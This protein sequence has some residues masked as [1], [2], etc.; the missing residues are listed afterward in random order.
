[1]EN[2]FKFDNPDITEG[3]IESLLG[4]KFTIVDYHESDGILA[5]NSQKELFIFKIENIYE[6]SDFQKIRHEAPK[7]VKQE[8]ELKRITKAYIICIV[9]FDFGQGNDYVYHGTT[10]FNGMT[11]G[12]IF[13]EYYI[14]RINS[15]SGVPT[16]PLDEWIYFLK[17][18]KVTPDA[19]A[20]GL[21]KVAGEFRQ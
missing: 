3:F 2:Y 8:D 11:S 18:A 19:T 1:M 9:Y 10:E 7:Y 15:F 6:Y 12:P 14:I 17:T 13:P 20:P 4:E 21:D 16:T 5:E